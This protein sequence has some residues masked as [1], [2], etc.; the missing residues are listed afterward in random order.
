MRQAKVVATD[1]LHL[2]HR[3]LNTLSGGERARAQ[4]ARAL[5]QIWEPVGATRWLLLDEPTAALDL[6]HQ[7]QTMA[8]ARRWAA[9]AWCGRGERCCT[10]STWPPVMPTMCWCCVVASAGGPWPL[11]APAHPELVQSVWSVACERIAAN[12]GTPQ[13]LMVA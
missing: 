11:A 9:R 13:F 12:D 3:V 7:H 8:L 2:A 4:L 5:A 6:S 1:V 10:T